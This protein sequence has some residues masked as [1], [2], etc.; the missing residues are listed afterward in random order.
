MLIAKSAS[1]TG[2]TVTVNFRANVLLALWP[3]FAV[4]V[5]V[6]VP[7]LLAPGVKVR[8]CVEPLPEIVGFG[9][10]AGLLD[11]AVSVTIWPASWMAETGPGMTPV[12]DKFWRP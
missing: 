12:I 8:V 5:M 6:A 3:S 1:S 4:T 2:L 7:F 9:T 10:S 11:T